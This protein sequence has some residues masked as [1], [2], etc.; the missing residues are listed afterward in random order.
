M[1]WLLEKAYSKSDLLDC[2]RH[3]PT[4]KCALFGCDLTAKT[5]G[6]PGATP[7]PNLHYSFHSD[8]GQSIGRAPVFTETLA[9][10]IMHCAW[11]AIAKPVNGE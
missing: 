10:Y 1:L 7:V 2:V 9:R 11:L 8:H 5:G 3:Q 6:H 4:W